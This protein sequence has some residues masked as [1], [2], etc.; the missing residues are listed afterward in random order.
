MSSPTPSPHKI[1]GSRLKNKV[2]IVTGGGSGFGEGIAR[3][4]AA[5]GA[6]VTI[7]DID[8][9]GGERVASESPSC[10]LFVKMDVANE[11]DWERVL[12]VTMGKW[13]RVDV[14][15]NNAGTSYRNKVR[16]FLREG[17]E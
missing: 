17:R 1:L 5:E 8:A 9:V 11:E 10:M 4:F 2:A 7:A 13:G 3:R 16:Y 12:E 15:V 14:V 6:K